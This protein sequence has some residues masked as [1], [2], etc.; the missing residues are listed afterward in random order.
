MIL[1]F[2]EMAFF[3]FSIVLAINFYKKIPAVCA[4]LLFIQTMLVSFWLLMDALVLVGIKPQIMHHIKFISIVSIPVLFFYTVSCYVNNESIFKKVNK[5]AFLIIPIITIILIASNQELGLIWKNINIVNEGSYT[6]IITQNGIMFWVHTV[7]SYLMIVLSLLVLMNKFVNSPP[8]YRRQSGFLLFGCLMTWLLNMVFVVENSDKYPLDPTPVSFLLILVIFYWGLFQYGV[9][10]IVPL[11]RDLIVENMEDLVLALDNAD[12]I[13]DINPSLKNRLKEF[14]I[15]SN[16]MGGNMLDLLNRIPHLRDQVVDYSGTKNIIWGEGEK[17][18]YYEIKRTSVIDKDGNNIG[19]LIILHDITNIQKVMKKL[20]YL[21]CYDQL[22]GLYNR[23]IFEIELDRLDSERQL[24]ISIIVGDVN[25]LK[26]I[27]NA[28]GHVTGDQLLK[29]VTEIIKIVMREEDIIARTGGDE[30]SIILPQTNEQDAA[31][32]IDRINKTCTQS[33]GKPIRISVSWGHAT[34]K[35]SE[36]DIHEVLKAA[37]ASMYKKKLLESKSTHG[38][39]VSS[40]IQTLKESSFETNEHAER[41]KAMSYKLG[42]ALKLSESQMDDLLLLALLH[43]LGKVAIPDKILEKPGKLTEEEWETMKRHT[44]IG[45]HIASS[46]N[47]LSPIAEHILSH[48]ERWDGQ[49]YPRGLSGESIPY[50]SRIISVVD[51]FDVMT[52]ERVYKK[53]ISEQE[54]IE[55]LLRCA[56]TQFDPVITE[57]FCGVLYA[58]KPKKQQKS[59]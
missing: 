10:R 2:L 39:I 59:G 14:N 24:P 22:T 32:I 45:Y 13:I 34:K 6:V 30:F 25:G 58:S 18:R 36:E 17:E 35:A 40:L 31:I 29:K 48:H 44:E 50:L 49:G 37:D 7:Y 21:T 9:Q 47:D 51:S 41:M 4:K 27:N 8:I 43:D 53:G 12:R 16:F 46:S 11:A 54:A 28:F 42:R 55:E 1:D 5:K 38:E 26:M 33:D 57:T 56:G 52:S 23:T 19:S 15:Q 3:L 20:E